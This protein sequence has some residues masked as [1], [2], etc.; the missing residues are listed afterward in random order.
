M[1]KYKIV[2][3]IIKYSTWFLAFMYLLNTILMY[4]GAYGTV[5]SWLAYTP[6]SMLIILYTMSI[7]LDFCIWHRLPL[8]YVLLCNITNILIWFGIITI[9]NTI[10]LWSNLVV[11]GF[12]ILLGAYLKNKYNEQNRTLKDNP[13]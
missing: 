3:I 9:T 5:I 4:F 12:L 7:V 11:F 1:K 13:S 2:L 6:F 8:Y 10:M